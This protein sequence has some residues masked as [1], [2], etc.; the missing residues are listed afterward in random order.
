MRVLCCRLSIFMLCVRLLALQY[1]YFSVYSN[2]CTKK[3]IIYL[4]HGLIPELG[5]AAYVE[6]DGDKKLE[7]ERSIDRLWAGNE[8][9]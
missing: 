8:T 1:I 7:L 4:V 3:K 9:R 5:T 6:R 2:I